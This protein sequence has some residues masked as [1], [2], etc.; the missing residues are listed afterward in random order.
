M[1][2]NLVDMEWSAEDLKV[3]DGALQI[4]REKF[5]VMPGLSAQQRRSIRRLGPQS[6]AFARHALD[7][8][9]PNRQ[10]VPRNIDVDGAFKDL[11]LFDQL[12]PRV[13]DLRMICELANDIETALGSDILRVAMDAYQ[14]LRVTGAREGLENA[15]RDLS[16]RFKRRRRRSD[17]PPAE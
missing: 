7:V 1:K 14:L 12:R 5:G 15:R 11:Q 10:M 2:H 6:E 4:L 8:I 3:I 16:V 17:I 9:G 13:N